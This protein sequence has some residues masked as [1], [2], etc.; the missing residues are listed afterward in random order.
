MFHLHHIYYFYWTRE[1]VIARSPATACAFYCDKKKIYNYIYNFGHLEVGSAKCEITQ[2]PDEEDMCGLPEGTILL[3]TGGNFVTDSNFDN[4]LRDM[5]D[6]TDIYTD[7]IVSLMP[8]FDMLTQN[9]MI[10]FGYALGDHVN[11]MAN[12]LPVVR[13]LLDN[14]RDKFMTYI[15]PFV[16]RDDISAENCVYCLVKAS[17]D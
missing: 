10:K 1:I 8:D 17:L 15:A 11:D 3:H 4:I 13:Y 6:S 12:M 7:I 9:Q 5:S 2:E 16:C 14:H